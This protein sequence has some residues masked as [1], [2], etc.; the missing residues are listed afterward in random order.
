LHW[1]TVLQVQ[2]ADLQRNIHNQRSR[3]GDIQQDVAYI[4]LTSIT[5]S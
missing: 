2:Q 5:N 1:Q 3:P 4:C